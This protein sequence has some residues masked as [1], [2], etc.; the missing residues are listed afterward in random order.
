MASYYLASHAE[1]YEGIILLGAYA[2]KPLQSERAL[3][4]YGSEDH[5]L[6]MEQYEENR[7][8]L[9]A[10]YV[11]LVI[12]GGCHAYFGAYGAQDGDG[13]PTI[14]AEAQWDITAQAIAEF[15]KK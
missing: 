1:A 3:S 9:P 14:S 10:D 15:V 2:A 5:V 6:N 11:E 8:N 7:A 12:D 4:I 13:I